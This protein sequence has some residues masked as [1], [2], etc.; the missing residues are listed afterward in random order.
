MNRPQSV[1]LIVTDAMVYCFDD[2]NTFLPDG[3][4]AVAGSRIV[5]V[6]PTDEILKAYQSS[7]VLDGQHFL[8]MPGLVNTHNHTPL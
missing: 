3:A 4:I 1:D 8:A 5:D 2:E 7:T 6:G